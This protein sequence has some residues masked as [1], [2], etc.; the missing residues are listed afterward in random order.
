MTSTNAPN[1]RPRSTA[2]RAAGRWRGAGSGHPGR[3]RPRGH[4]LP[5]LRRR[6][7]L[8]LRLLLLVLLLLLLRLLL[9]VLLVSFL[10]VLLLLL[11]SSSSFLLVSPCSFAPFFF[12]LRLLANP[13]LLEDANRAFSLGLPF[14][15]LA[16]ARLFSPCALGP[17]SSGLKRISLLLLGQAPSLPRL[18]TV[19]QPLLFLSLASSSLFLLSFPSSSLLLLLGLRAASCSSALSRAASSEVLSLASSSPPL[20]PQPCVGQPPPPQP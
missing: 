5:R 4:L 19:E 2:P 1:T 14:R 12:P 10:L 20:L 3:R 8:L 6:L 18:R 16:S 7:L 13:I 9:L 17:S 15:L 11:A